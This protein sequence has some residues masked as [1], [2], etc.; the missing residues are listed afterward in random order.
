[1]SVRYALNIFELSILTYNYNSNTISVYNHRGL[2]T[3]DIKVTFHSC[4]M[5]SNIFTR[6][7]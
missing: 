2:H 4:H 1:M 7:T 5:H 6:M 3:A